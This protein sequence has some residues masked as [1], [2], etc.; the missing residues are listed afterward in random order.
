MPEREHKIA[1]AAAIF[2]E[3]WQA[4]AWQETRFVIACSGGPDST[5]LVRFF[6]QL[7]PRRDHLIVAHFHH[8]LRSDSA[9]ADADFVRQLADQLG[10]AF[11]TDRVTR[12]A[13]E[14][15]TAGQG[16]ES[17]ARQLR[18]DFLTGVAQQHGARYLAAGH[19][20]D[21]QVET[22]LHHIIRGTSW[23]GLAG[24]PP[25]RQINESL[26]LVRPLLSWSRAE[27]LDFLALLEQPFRHD[28]HN[29]SDQFTRNRIRN[30]LLPMLEAR[31]HPGVRGAIQR[32]SQLA[33]ET[34]AFFQERAAELLDRAVSSVTP[35][36]VVELNAAQLA[37][38]HPLERRAAF[39]ELWRRQQWPAQDMSTAHWQRLSD[40]CQQTIATSLGT[41]PISF[42]LPGSVHLSRHGE[43]LRL[44]RETNI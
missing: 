28:E 43:T 22:V 19:N 31:Y 3:R 34:Q 2:L 20:A 29:D 25:V 33:T 9:D 44:K 41:L 32:L 40:A 5:A 39:A 42:D 18:Y 10:L 27:I 17:A 38:A 7:H 8:G 36:D 26:S 24:I 16:W 11:V 6:H 30:E 21:D 23:T 14:T 37:T 15:L 13:Y 12:A 4:P 1:Q 35:A